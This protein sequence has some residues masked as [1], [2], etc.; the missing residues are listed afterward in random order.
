MEETPA[1]ETEMLYTLLPDKLNGNKLMSFC[2]RLHH[3]LFVVSLLIGGEW[4]MVHRM[5]RL[6]AFFFQFRCSIR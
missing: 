4:H 2:H 6:S 5:D 3:R 1:A